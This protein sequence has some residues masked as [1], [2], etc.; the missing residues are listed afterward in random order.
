MTIMRKAFLNIRITSTIDIVLVNLYQIIHGK[1][2]SHQEFPHGRS[3][4]QS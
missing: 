4:V 2:Q 1:G 3:N